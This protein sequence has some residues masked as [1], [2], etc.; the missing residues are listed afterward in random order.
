MKDM[1]KI[2][3]PHFI[4]EKFSPSWY[5]TRKR[6]LIR[7]TTTHTTE[8][9]L[10]VIICNYL[11]CKI[12]LKLSST[13]SAAGLDE[14]TQNIIIPEGSE[15]LVIILRSWWSLDIRST[16]WPG[17]GYN[18]NIHRTISIF[19]GMRAPSWGILTSEGKV[20]TAGRETMKVSSQSWEHNVGYHSNYN[21][22]AQNDEVVH[23]YHH[24]WFPDP[25]ILPIRGKTHEDMSDFVPALF[26]R[27]THHPCR[28]LSMIQSSKSS[29]YPLCEAN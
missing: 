14:M 19:P 16:G 1:R 24:S 12:H 23:S 9:N 22:I 29:F 21:N 18:Q 2:F 17:D 15:T 3:R 11:P 5:Q 8:I 25:C 28:V 13:V 20:Q 27:L 7:L 6:R 26:L 10:R 4:S